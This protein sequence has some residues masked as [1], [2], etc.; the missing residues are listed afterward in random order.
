MFINRSNCREARCVGS[1]TTLTKTMAFKRILARIF[2]IVL[3]LSMSSLSSYPQVEDLVTQMSIWRV[4]ADAFTDRIEKQTF[5]IDELEKAVLFAKLGK[6]WAESDKNKAIGFFEKSVDTLFF[7]S[8]E[9]I[10]KNNQAYL[11][12][13]RETL[14]I[15][16]NR[17]PRQTKRLISIL[18]DSE[19]VLSENNQLSS[20]TLIEFALAIVKDDAVQATELGI[21][22]FRFG[23]P[24]KFY[25]L[26]WELSKANPSLTDR[27]FRRI[28]QAATDSPNP[29]IAQNL[30]LSIFHENHVSGTIEQRKETL[31]F[32]ANFINQ[33]QIKYTAKLIDKCIFE[34]YILASVQDQ[35][36]TYLPEKTNAVKQSIALCIADNPTPGLGKSR[37]GLD[38]TEASSVEEL[39]KL[40]DEAKDNLKN[41][42]YYLFRAVALANDQKIY[43]IG[44]EIL[45]GMSK[46]ER[47]TDIEF[48]DT[49][50]YS[51]AGGLAFQQLEE[52]DPAAATDTLN[53]VPS[54]TRSFA[55]VGF[56]FRCSTKDIG[57]REFC[58]G[59]IDEAVSD[60]PKSDKLLAEKYRFWLLTIKLY[61][62]YGQLSS[63]SAS[64][65]A[66]VKRLNVDLA[67]RKDNSFH[68]ATDESPIAISAE[69]LESQEQTLL[70]AVDLLDDSSSRTNVNL[71]FLITA[72][73]K[74]EK[75]KK[76]IKKIPKVENT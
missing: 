65:E 63:A 15:L 50:R 40:A 6:L 39:I 61:A 35:Y 29:Q 14:T 23:Q 64:F 28:I 4:R 71:A 36:P 72:L 56:A 49:L 33:Q 38:Q 25:Q 59:K 66:L 13:I 73:D 3:I 26:F 27:F 53:A 11:E 7:Y 54:N 58:I 1:S 17:S 22:S 21:L 8:S 37:T 24:T 67:E 70:K 76:L 46:Q 44:I 48:W 51:S 57:S 75:L 42:T 20:D 30:K 43:R 10:R 32:L 18:S 34:A 74:I 19:K 47:A 16:A 60:F 55:K 31:R 68:L 69:L 45:N 5:K 62:E 9:E 41:R 52:G 12:S 2:L